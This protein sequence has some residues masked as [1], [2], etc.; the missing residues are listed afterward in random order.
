[1]PIASTRD[2]AE[3]FSAGKVH[4]Q[5]FM[6][7]AGQAGNDDWQDWSYASGQPSYDARIG[8]GSLIFSPYTA[9][10][11]DAIFFPPIPAGEERHIAG[12]GIYTG[13]GGNDQ[14][15]ATAELY[16]LLGVYPLID[17]DSTDLQTMDNTLTLPRY[18][19]GVGVRVALVNHV[20][21]AVTSNCLTTI[22]Y[23]DADDT[24]RSV[25]VYTRN[26]GINRI[27]A[28]AASG[29]NRGTIW[30]PMD[31]RGVKSI[32]SL[33]FSSAPGGLWA[34]YLFVPLGRISTQGGAAGVNQ[35]VFSEKCFCSTESFNLPRIYDGAWLGF[36]YMTSTGTSRTA[37]LFGNI[38][39]IWG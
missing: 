4:T 26:D 36:F 16:D 1:M 9:V 5:R 38:T 15:G 25:Q 6:K 21:P 2:I 30:L 7:S 32:T 12:M 34:L 28:T 19:D 27:N 20:A 31:G 35:S 14:L 17:G 33:T 10:G 18:A 23:I 29:G 11:N 8:T 13:P 37:T 3:A 22:N 24:A 39:F